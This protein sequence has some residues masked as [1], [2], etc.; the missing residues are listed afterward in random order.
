MIEIAA[1]EARHA[2]LSHAVHAWIV[3]RLDE[4]ARAR[5]A[6]AQLRAICE[7]ASGT[8]TMGDEL[9]RAAGLPSTE[10]SQAMIH[11]LADALWLPALRAA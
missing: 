8:G 1:D 4:D 5:V 2:A 10:L 3:P 6:R 7:L 9:Q 11:A